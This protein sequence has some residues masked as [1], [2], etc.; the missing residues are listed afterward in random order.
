[1]VQTSLKM[2]HIKQEYLISYYYV[3]IICN[4]ILQLTKTMEFAHLKKDHLAFIRSFNVTWS[5]VIIFY[6]L[7]L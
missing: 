1:M 5:Y 6:I 7:L 3:K 2:I 4:K